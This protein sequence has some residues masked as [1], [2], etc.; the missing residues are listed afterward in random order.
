MK[1]YVATIEA[2][3][4]GFINGNNT[5]YLEN[6]MEDGVDSWITPYKK[7][8]LPHHDKKKDSLGSQRI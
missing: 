6:D 7:P 3:H 4:G 1:Q 2:T 8:V 5:W